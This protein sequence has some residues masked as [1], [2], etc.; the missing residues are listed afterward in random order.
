MVKR[1]FHYWKSRL[2]KF[3]NTI[4]LLTPTSLYMYEKNY[5]F[6]IP[7]KFDFKSNNDV[8]MGTTCSVSVSGG[9]EGACQWQ[10]GVSYSSPRIPGGLS[11]SIPQLS[12]QR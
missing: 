10:K 5:L 1:L 12:L 9:H 6:F 8:K 11:G 3:L 4:N 7:L 2:C